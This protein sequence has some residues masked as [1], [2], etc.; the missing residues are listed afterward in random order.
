MKETRM[1]EAPFDVPR[2]H[3]WFGVEFNNLAW[4]LVEKAERSDEESARMIHAAHASCLHW[5]HVGAAVN[6]LRGE[7]LLATAYAAAGLFEAAGRHAERGLELSREVGDEQT[8]FDRATALGCA[9]RAYAGL[10]RMEAARERY[11]EA[12]QAAEGLEAEDRG[13]FE[14]LYPAP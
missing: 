13:V 7:C 11:R 8:A 9:A 1:A 12:L 10:G 4:D 5:Q 2:A 14:R 3:R 6:Q